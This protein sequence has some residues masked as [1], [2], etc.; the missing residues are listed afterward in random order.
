M[1]QQRTV[2]IIEDHPIVMAGCLRLLEGH[3]GMT[4]LSAATGEEGL[5]VSAEQNPDV[6]ILDLNLPDVSGLDVLRAMLEASPNLRVLIFSSYEDPAFASRALDAGAAGYVTKSDDP[7]ILIEA[8]TQI[9]KGEIYLSRSVAQRLAMMNIR[10]NGNPL[11]GLNPRELDILEYLSKGLSLYEISQELDVGYRT[12][13]SISAGLRRRLG[14][15][16]M[17]A[18]VKFAVDN[19]P[20]RRA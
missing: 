2:L 9:S 1:T 12:I 17:F 19:A 15:I 20:I 10:P 14:N 4:V 8:L 13:A 7:G 18:L 5:R 6:V 16:N 3:Q 11:Q